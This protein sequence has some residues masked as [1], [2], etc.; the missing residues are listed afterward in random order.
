[1]DESKIFACIV[2]YQP[3]IRLLEKVV[4]SVASQ[5]EEVLIFDNNSC[6]AGD[7]LKLVEK[8]TDSTLVKS[9]NNIGIAGALNCLAVKANDMNATA[10]LTLD[11]DTICPDNLVSTLSDHLTDDVAIASPMVNDRHVEVAPVSNRSGV[12]ECTTPFKNAPITSGS[13]V[14]VPWYLAVGGYND[15]FFIDYVDFDFN[16]RVLDHGLRILRVLDVSIS[17]AIG[18]ASTSWVLYPYLTRNF[19]VRF[20]RLHRTGHNPIRTYY[21]FRN[22]ILYTKLHWR[23]SLFRYEGIAQ[24]PVEFFRVIFVENNKFNNLAA[25]LRGLRDGIIIRPERRQSLNI[26]RSVT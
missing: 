3:D 26:R 2:T 9:S 11:Q 20:R 13:L 12:L 7:I 1:M 10:I 25:S 19:D 21:K 5:V 15:Q 16:R 23:K 14:S 6:N 24:I 8:N 17:H 4:D 22:R 18:E